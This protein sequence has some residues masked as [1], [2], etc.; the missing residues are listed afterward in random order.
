MS[1]QPPVGDIIM[2]DDSMPAEENTLSNATFKR[3]RKPR[4]TAKWTTEMRVVAH[5]VCSQIE[6]GTALR[7][8]VFNAIF[9][10]H[11]DSCGLPNGVMYAEIADQHYTRTAKA[12][13]AV[14]RWVEGNKILES[15][16]GTELLMQVMDKAVE[17]GYVGTR[18]ESYIDKSAKPQLPRVTWTAEMR[19]VAHLITNNIVDRDPYTLRTEVFDSVCSEQLDRQGLRGRVEYS[20]IFS[21]CSRRGLKL[22]TKAQEKQWAEADELQNSDR[23]KELLAEVMRVSVEK[24]PDRHPGSAKPNLRWTIEMRATAY[25]ISR[26][27][28]DSPLHARRAAIFNEMYGKHLADCGFPAGVGYPVIH[29]QLQ[30]PNRKGKGKKWPAAMAIAG[31]ERGEE[32]LEIVRQLASAN[33]TDD[34]PDGYVFNGTTTPKLRWTG[35]MMAAIHL[36]NTE[37]EDSAPFELHTRIFNTMFRDHLAALGY[38][39]GIAHS[40]IRSK[41]WHK[42]SGK[43]SEKS[44]QGA[45]ALVKGETGA[46]LLEM[47]KEIAGVAEPREVVY[48][49]ADNAPD[50]Y[51]AFGTET[52]VANP[53]DVVYP[54]EEEDTLE[55]TAALRAA[56]D[57]PSST[58]PSYANFEDVLGM[59]DDELAESLDSWLASV[60]A[61]GRR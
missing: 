4:T 56:L 61:G 18:P 60:G 42:N 1:D 13:R 25:L 20:A 15:E 28:Q 8:D 51:V 53:D 33:N 43:A 22:K 55:A 11:L 41:L 24:R 23:G 30:M 54:D 49:A 3:E 19:V 14:K 6:S 12:K 57:M 59:D 38:P 27:I 29:E 10:D 2:P 5:L 39:D 21:Q 9:A 40:T 31:S 50:G 32:L 58:T 44:W 34:D 45:M 36:I 26:E 52:L 17:M 35:E 46:E 7:T 48:A 16:R 37:I 47:A